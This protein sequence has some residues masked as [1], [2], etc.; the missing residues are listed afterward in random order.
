MF[1]LYSRLLHACLKGSYM[2]GFRVYS[3]AN[4]LL[5]ICIHS[6]KLS[7]FWKGIYFLNKLYIFTVKSKSDNVKIS[8]CNQPFLGKFVI[9][10][11]KTNNKYMIYSNPSLY[12]D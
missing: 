8:F 5:D 4:I 12:H 11:Q 9:L 3:G 7:T 2:N 1:S 10:V 6:L